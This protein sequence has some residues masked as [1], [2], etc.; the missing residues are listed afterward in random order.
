MDS[1]CY[2]LLAKFVDDPRQEE[3][4]SLCAKYPLQL[5]VNCKRCGHHTSTL[6]PSLPR[7]F[8]QG[9]KYLLYTVKHAKNFQQ[10][11]EKI[12]LYCKSATFIRV[13]RIPISI[14]LIYMYR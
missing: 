8:S 14:E 1:Y 9:K 10:R 13:Q 6:A 3:P 12:T 5:D 11:Q 2:C 4:L 7:M